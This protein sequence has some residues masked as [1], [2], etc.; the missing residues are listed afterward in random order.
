MR[1]SSIMF[2]LALGLAACSSD[3]NKTDQRIDG[4]KSDRGPT[5]DLPPAGD[6][7]TVD[8][9]I[10]KTDGTKDGGGGSCPGTTALAVALTVGTGGKVGTEVAGSI[11]DPTKGNCFYKLLGKKGD[12]LWI[13]TTAKT[14]TDPFDDTYLDT[15]LTMVDSNGKQ[16]A[17]NDD[18]VPR[19]TNDA[20]LYTVLPADGTYYL[21]VSECNAIFGINSCSD[22]TLIT[23]KDF[24]IQV[25]T[26]EFP[27]VINDTEPNDDQAHSIAVTYQATSTTGLYFPAI[28]AGLFV[29]VGDVDVYT[30]QTPA[31]VTI[32]AGARS[33]VQVVPLPWGMEGNGS[34]APIGKMWVVDP[35]DPTHHLAE[36]DASL[37]QTPAELTPPLPLNKPY[38]LFVT[39]TSGTAAGNNEFYFIAQDP[40][41]LAN[42][43]EADEAGGAKNDTAATATALTA[44]SSNPNAFY[45]EGD[46]SSASDVDYYSVAIPAG[47]TDKTVTVACGA[48][49]SG[50]GLR[51][52]KIS[53]FKSDGTTL[54]TGSATVTETA[55]DD[56]LLE[57]LALG[58][59]TSKLI[60]KLEATGA[61]DTNV[62]SSYY[63]CG[64][65]FL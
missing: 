19:L 16:V 59:E 15:V 62:T 3:N 21:K 29:N 6:G 39:R 48:Q 63:R 31:D 41:G 24:T 14:G 27:F 10:V 47:L 5:A 46:L 61:H 40:N 34:T 57:D 44:S 22:P 65:S 33:S 8:K 55:A 9:K 20:E 1:T 32:S 25:Q 49:R 51:G 54:L 7:S 52:L 17:Q 18:P 2:L 12:R 43:L 56:A 28:I 35:A 13:F 30:I 60:L 64:V 23:N 50:S 4:G 26:T 11:Y 38:Y 36:V 58:T 37:G 53:L 45:L 42:Q